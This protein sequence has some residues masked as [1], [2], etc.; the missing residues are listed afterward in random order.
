MKSRAETV[1]N[2]FILKNRIS[3]PVTALIILS[4]SVLLYFIIPSPDTSV[5][6]IMGVCSAIYFCRFIYIYRIAAKLNDI[7]EKE[8]DP[9]LF[10]SV[11]QLLI[12]R[13]AF[14]HQTTSVS[15]NVALGLNLQGKFQQA[16][17][18]LQ[19]INV[20][21]KPP[22]QKLFYL[23]VYSACAHAKR[24]SYTVE[25]CLWQALHIAGTQRR[26][27]RV[28]RYSSKLI[29][30]LNLYLAENN[31]QYDVALEIANEM[32]ISAKLPIERV[33]ASFYIAKQ[34]FHKG[35][36]SSAKAYCEYVIQNGNKLHCVVLAKEL[37]V[38]YGN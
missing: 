14:R 5:L 25:W 36:C 38:K 26:S 33:S 28:S 30:I 24:D 12:S 31:K 13:N 17:N 7:L 11:F 19:E 18:L 2:G 20:N 9:E 4:T 6:F 37:L 15:L 22:I 23:S 32:L 3:I 1:A 8:C 34:L 35:D 21:T 27:P 16:G 29:N 10:T